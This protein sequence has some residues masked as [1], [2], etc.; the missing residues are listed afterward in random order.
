MKT[1]TR[2]LLL[3]ISISGCFAQADGSQ[4]Y[5]FYLHGQI[6][7][8]QGANAYHQQYGKYEYHQII[9]TFENAG[10]T[11]ISEI[12]P[13]Q[14]DH[15]VYAKKV[16]QQ[17]EELIKSGVPVDKITVLGCSKGSVIAMLV[18]TLLQNPKLNY[19][20]M[21]G[22]NEYV[23]NTFSPKLC[24]RV[25]SIYETTD[26]IGKSCQSI[27]NASLCCPGWEELALSTGKGHGLIYQ[28]LPQWTEPA[29]RW[30]KM[31]PLVK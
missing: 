12:R 24:G 23:E 10:L 19:V 5:L 31:Q 26:E 18:S 17:I 2:F 22:C 30:A 13:P 8:N 1:C 25:L 28:P 6:V 7:E 3:T 11:V 16:V 4:Y 15:R 27:F 20:L 21:V 9:E 14:T 29:A